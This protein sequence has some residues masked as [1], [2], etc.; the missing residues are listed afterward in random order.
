MPASTPIGE[1]DHAVGVGR[2]D[3][4]VSDHHDRVPVLVN[5]LAQQPEDAAAGAGVQCSGRLV[6]E[7]DLGRGH[8]RT[9]YR[10]PLLL[11]AGELGWAVSQTLLEPDSC[12]DRPHGATLCATAVQAQRQRDVLHDCQRG[13]QVEGLEDEPDPLASEDRQAPLAESRE[14]GAGEGDGAGGG[15]I[16][17]GS[18]VQEGALAGTRGSH[19]R[20]EGPAGKLD[21]DPV[22]GGNPAVAVA[23]HLSNLAQGDHRGSVPGSSSDDQRDPPRSPWPASDTTPVS[24]LILAPLIGSDIES[25]LPVVMPRDHGGS[26]VSVGAAPGVRGYGRPPERYGQPHGT[27]SGV[28]ETLGMAKTVLIVDDHPSFRAS[29]R[30]MLEADGYEV[31][32]RGREWSPRTCSQP[33]S[34]AQSSCCWTFASRTWTG[35]RSRGG[36][37]RRTVRT[38][39][40]SSS[41][42]TTPVT[43]GEDVE[44]SGASGF[45]AKGELSAE[46]ITLLIR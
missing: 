22:E 24:A 33:R 36:C 14:V 28:R 30:R 35:S 31:D 13:H 37:S 3:G 7:N 12:R 15:P 44:L 8:E 4:I 18:H 11:P 20:G 43:F 40:S 21:I 29:A 6:G 25:S 17:S 45:V 41:P 42:V 38:R 10:H 5:D 26:P 27:A 19:D 1:H 32:R 46:A 23:V 34:C 39:R 2:C 16:Q 9:G